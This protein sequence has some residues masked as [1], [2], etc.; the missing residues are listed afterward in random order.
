[1]DVIFQFP[2]IDRR[3]A[4]GNGETLN[5]WPGANTTQEALYSRRPF[6]RNFGIISSSVEGYY[7]N[8]NCIKY[9]DLHYQGLQ[10]NKDASSAIVNSSKKLYS[11][12]S[13]AKK[14]EISFTDNLEYVLRL[15]EDK[16]PVNITA[17][18]KHYANLPINVLNINPNQADVQTKGD[19]KT[20]NNFTQVSL[21]E[22]GPMLAKE[23][24]NATTS[25]RAENDL[26]KFVICGEVY[27][28]IIFPRDCGIQL[29]DNITL[30]QHNIE[31]TNISLFGFHW[32]FKNQI[33][34]VCLFE[35]PQPQEKLSNRELEV[36]E[37]KRLQMFRLNT[38]TDATLIIVKENE[39]NPVGGKDES[40]SKKFLK[41]N[42][43]KF[44]KKRRF[45]GNQDDIRDFVLQ[46]K[47][48]A[49]L[50]ADFNRIAGNDKYSAENLKKIYE[51]V[52]ALL[53][54]KTVL[55]V[56]SNPTEINPFDFGKAYD[57][58]VNARKAGKERDFF[59]EV[60][61]KLSVQKDKIMNSFYE[62]GPDFLHITLHN[63]TARGFYFQD[64][65]GNADPVSVDKFAEYIQ[66]LSEIKRP[67]AIILCACNSLAHAEAV[68]NYCGY[69]MGTDAVFPEDV[70]ILYTEKFYEAL[71]N[72]LEITF[73]HNVAIQ[74]IKDKFTDPLQ[75]GHNVY[76]ILE[77][78]HPD[79]YTKN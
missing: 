23:Y 66:L 55:F 16:Q 1:M 76:E 39:I 17:I 37:N 43:E 11:D 36:L 32:R 71:F 18:L 58:M 31:G 12:G 74:A 53:P 20:V 13:F 78:I 21:S 44:F 47:N 6:I 4:T 69:A 42:C 19:E 45:Q 24:F 50:P 25:H 70:S 57:S 68:K 62:N 75:D 8:V 30:L 38:E 61:P 60:I 64:Q 40:E 59:N 67:E 35:L 10:V 33:F 48:A 52:K 15:Q 9:D 22:A 2:I 26:S 46:N 73:C 51:I 79:T 41:K 3:P 34:K 7:C 72:G 77:L 5:A 14:I 56:T 27:I 49:L 65:D 28:A 63:S 29:P 54:K